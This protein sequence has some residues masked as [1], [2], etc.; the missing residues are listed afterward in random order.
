MTAEA[1]FQSDAFQNDAFQ[2]GGETADTGTSVRMQLPDVYLKFRAEKY[3]RM[4]TLP[5]RA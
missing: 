5:R 4:R 1:A 2:I 3:A